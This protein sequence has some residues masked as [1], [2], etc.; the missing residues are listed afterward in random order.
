M[1][2]WYLCY[3]DILDRKTDGVNGGRGEQKKQ[4]VEGTDWVQATFE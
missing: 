2:N 3:F 1:K 4:T